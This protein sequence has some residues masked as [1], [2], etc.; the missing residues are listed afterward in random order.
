[1]SFCQSRRRP[2]VALAAVSAALLVASACGQP[3]DES[4][5]GPDA[6]AAL[7]TPTAEVATVGDATS[8]DEVERDAA[9]TAVDTSAIVPL[10]GEVA[11]IVWAL[12]YGDSVV[13]TD[14]SATYPEQ[15]AQLPKIG[16]QRALASEGI[17][18]FGP[19]IVVGTQEAGPPEVIEQVSDAG[20]PVEIIEAGDT[21]ESAGQK[22]RDVAAALGDSAAGEVLAS[23]TE[24]EIDAA[25]ERV[26]GVSER[27]R[28]VF[29]Y[30]R[31]PQT[32]LIGGEGT[33][34]HHLIEAAGGI[35]AAAE[36]GVTGTVPV[37]A[38]ALATAA[39]DIVLTTAAGLESVGG[40]DGLL[41][42][43]GI[44]QTPAGSNG[45][46]VALEDQYLLGL[47]P[48]TGQALDELID[49]L[50]PDLAAR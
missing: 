41:A 33:R 50:H 29:V 45:T 12:G 32:Q 24:A 16:Y 25:L 28:V 20:I 31:G 43:P 9:A 27:P 1:M 17:I 2:A 19:T 7:A 11:E 8:D 4:S 26:A 34:G 48:R 22:I 42:L 39:P 21:V 40:V 35:D 44:A 38:E 30:L 18:A 15:A 36:A 37:T 47:G 6:E 3:T 10:N 5:A 49:G 13:A 46:V 14:T 23:T